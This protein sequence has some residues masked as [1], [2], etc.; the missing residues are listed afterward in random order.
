MI[1]AHGEVFMLPFEI[2]GAIS[3]AVIVIGIAYF[4][5]RDA[6]RF[7]RELIPVS[8]AIVILIAITGLGFAIG[9][10]YG[11][12]IAPPLVVAYVLGRRQVQKK[13][14]PEKDANTSA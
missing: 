1:F 13:S 10:F 5:A 6:F 3:G 8:W 11:L 4:I 9:R 2:A 7:G 12:L 14:L